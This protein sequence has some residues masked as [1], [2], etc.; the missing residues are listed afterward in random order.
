[1]IS[2]SFN[3][4]ASLIRPAPGATWAPR[5]RWYLIT[6]APREEA[7]V[8]KKI[9]EALEHQIFLP[10]DVRPT[11]KIRGKPRASDEVPLL[12]CR[13]FVQTELSGWMRIRNLKHVTGFKCDPEGF[14]QPIPD[15]Q[16]ETFRRVHGEAHAEAQKRAALGKV[17]GRGARA[18]KK[19]MPAHEALMAIKEQMD[20]GEPGP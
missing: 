10:M 11:R 18:K 6:T 9:A 17:L 15:D 5:A 14:P 4:L 2:R 8:A 16:M 20:G 13:V 7:R 12:P 3:A 1:M 19:F